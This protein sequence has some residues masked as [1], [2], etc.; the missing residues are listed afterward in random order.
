MQQCN[1]HASHF[2]GGVVP[3]IASGV[4]DA[5]H[6]AKHRHNR[7]VVFFHLLSAIGL[8][9]TC[10]LRGRCKGIKIKLF[11]DGAIS[12]FRNYEFFTLKFG[13]LWKMHIKWK[14][15]IFNNTN[16]DTYFTGLYGV[17]HS[18]KFQVDN[19][20][21]LPQMLG[22]FLPPKA[23]QMMTPDFQMRFLW[24][25]GDCMKKRL[26][27]WIPEQKL[28]H[29]CAFLS[30]ICQFQNLTFCDLTLIKPSLKVP[31]NDFKR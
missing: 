22:T 11:A 12:R 15:K 3:E 28:V 26:S 30:D 10:H 1:N 7:A 24:H 17:N 20:I 8:L 25:L 23:H 29:I 31:K 5:F 4:V 14:M 2:T 13:I 27:H 18:I 16:R 9:L 6:N 19:S 21:F